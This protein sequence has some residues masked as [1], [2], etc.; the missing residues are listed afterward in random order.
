MCPLDSCDDGPELGR[1]RG[2]VACRDVDDSAET[3]AH[4]DY[5]QRF[6]F[7]VASVAQ[8]VPDF[9][10]GVYAEMYVAAVQCFG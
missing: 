10:S 8:H 4:R 6:R 9:R 5:R 1:E 7:A 3:V 2:V